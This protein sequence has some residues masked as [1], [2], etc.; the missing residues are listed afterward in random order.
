MSTKQTIAEL[1][2]AI[3][4]DS[5]EAERS[6]AR[7]SKS[8]KKAKDG[9]E[10]LG[11][12]TE[13][14]ELRLKRLGKAG[15][16][17][18]NV[19]S[20]L[21]KAMLAAGAAVG[22]LG[23]AV[24]S[25]GA[26][27]EKLRAQLKTATGSAENAEAA[28]S[29][30]KDFARN[31]PFQVDQITEAFVKLTNLGLEPSARAL[32]SY[33]DTASAMGKELDQ[34]IEAA[35]DAVTGEFERLKEFG[36]KAKSEGDRVA[37]TFRGITTEVG[38][39]SRE[40]EEFLIGLGEQNFAGAMS[41][42]M[43]TLGGLVSNLKDAF[44]DF[45]L[46]V[47]EMGP[48]DEFKALVEDLRDASGDKTG[49]ARTLAK[50]LVQAIR[51]LRR[52]LSGDLIE[53]LKRAASTLEFVVTNFRSF[54]GVI[55]GAKT[56]QA[57][58]QIAAGFRN[59]GIAAGASLGPIGAIASALLAL[60]PI[61]L[62]VGNAIGDVLVKRGRLPTD[63]GARGGVQ[64]GVGLGAQ[65]EA[66]GVAVTSASSDLQKA[67]RRLAKANAG[68]NRMSQRLAR[69]D[70]REKRSILE[71]EQ[72]AAAKRSKEL[73]AQRKQEAAKQQ[74]EEKQKQAAAAR[75]EAEFGGF[76]RDVASLREQLGI[77][78]EPTKRQ[79][80]A[81]DE[82]ISALAEGK[83][84]SAALKKAD[85][86]GRG[87]GRKKAKKK[88]EKKITSPTTVS[89]FFGAAARGE[90][91]PIA[92]RTPATKDIEPTVA[93]DITNNNFSFKIDQKIA[94]VMDPKA[95]GDAAGAAIKREFDLRLA[96]AGQQLASNLVR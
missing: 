32:T 30:I 93:V 60:I 10:D 8:L 12:E 47:A 71:R 53:T 82:G 34:F 41:E 69:D 89:E 4:V 1:L 39:N 68:S 75:E 22:G 95:A 92:A 36:I 66:G 51:T 37:F 78:G 50:T 35:A 25:T 14:T 46:Q 24:I 76:D 81:L 64:D 48:L 23:K 62:D 94:G 57:F 18:G 56:F 20:A 21:S 28:L 31:T 79:Q 61:A 13:K 45:M 88:P 86:R 42:Q 70:V 11:D 9:A 2:V 58:T 90:L 77:E 7:L 67:E 74:Q 19:A 40:I 54:L 29:F 83:T 27:F 5:K 72:K 17:A 65:L 43:G 15:D 38:K 96:A 87:G 55:A 63:G 52:V 3:G 44:T 84:L 33:G 26:R 6:A 85:K 73:A 91:G 80:R 49:L 59:M 16:I